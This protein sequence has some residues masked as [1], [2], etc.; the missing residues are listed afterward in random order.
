VA[1]LFHC[2]QNADKHWIAS[3]FQ[4]CA[5][6]VKSYQE[7]T[8]YMCLIGFVDASDACLQD[9]DVILIRVTPYLYV[10]FNVACG[11]NLHTEKPNTIVV[12]KALLDGQVSTQK[13]ALAM[14]GKTYP[15]E[16]SGEAL[17]TVVEVCSMVLREEFVSHAMISVHL[18][19][20]N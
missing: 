4:H 9:N 14:P 12:V 17:G 11:F 7:G 6:T 20:A 8:S 5:I 1:V 18:A 15:C 10:Q 13:A 3:W 16:N 19:N 2:A